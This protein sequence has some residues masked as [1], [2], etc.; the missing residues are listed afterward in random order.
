MSGTYGTV[1]KPSDRPAMKRTACNF[2]GAW[3]VVGEMG[4]CSKAVRVGVWRRPRTVSNR[5]S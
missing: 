2:A 4:R 5:G 3:D 1:R